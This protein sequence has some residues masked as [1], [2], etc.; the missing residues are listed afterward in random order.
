MGFDGR[1]FM[2][3]QMIHSFFHLFFVTRGG[4]ILAE[5]PV[6]FHPV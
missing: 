2:M 6:S 4:N 1:D 5:R 3:D